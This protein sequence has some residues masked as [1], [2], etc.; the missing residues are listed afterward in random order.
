MC[1][2]TKASGMHP[3]EG[4]GSWSMG[5]SGNEQLGLLSFFLKFIYSF[6]KRLR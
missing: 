6:C 5:E 3:W 1:K 2:D 4:E